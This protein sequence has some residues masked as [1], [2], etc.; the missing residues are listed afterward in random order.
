MQTTTYVSSARLR[1]VNGASFHKGTMSIVHPEYTRIVRRRGG[2]TEIITTGVRG[3]V[4]DLAVVLLET[5]S[6]VEEA[7]Q[8]G[9]ED[10]LDLCS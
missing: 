4:V 1:A 5:A 10:E 3:R 8:C 9:I 7:C 6:T 2:S